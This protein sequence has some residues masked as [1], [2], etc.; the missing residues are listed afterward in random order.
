M[1]G[2]NTLVLVSETLDA[3]TLF[4][5]RLKSV[6]VFFSSAL[7]NEQLHVHEIRSALFGYLQTGFCSRYIEGAV[8]IKCSI[9]NQQQHAEGINQLRRIAPPFAHQERRDPGTWNHA[10]PIRQGRGIQSPVLK[11]KL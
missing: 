9:P 6:P 4:D 5:T 2:L 10:A 3:I 8:A 7:E 1:Q 11:A